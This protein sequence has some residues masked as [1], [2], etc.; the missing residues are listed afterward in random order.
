MIVGMAR[1]IISSA[2]RSLAMLETLHPSPSKRWLPEAFEA[3]RFRGI[4]A[5]CT[6]EKN[7]VGCSTI[8]PG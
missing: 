3:P 1:A 8:G 7:T 2:M 5:A 4:S 6:Y